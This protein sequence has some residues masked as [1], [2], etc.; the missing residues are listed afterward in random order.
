MSKNVTI[1][2]EMILA[3]AFDIVREK[4]LEG[5]SNRELAKKLNCSIRPIYYQ[6]QNVEELYNELYVEI[7]KYFYK[8]LMDNMNDDMPKY[9]QV[10]LNYIKF[11][12]EEKEFFKILFMSEVDLGL[13]DFI[14]KDMEDFKEL[15][16]L[17]KIST[18]LNDEDIESFHI[19]MWIFSHGLATLVASSTLN[20][21]DK[22]L[23]Q[24]LSL[25]FQALMLLKENPN[26][27]WVLKNGVE[28]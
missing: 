24:L 21:S 7:E 10:G 15:S 12:K 20:I 6:F 27:K 14:A 22:Q 18:N 8:F 25:E 2:K 3:S 28:K 16:K 19:K 13:N 26:N 23:K 17:I 5:I 4:G 9:K 11:A 1:T